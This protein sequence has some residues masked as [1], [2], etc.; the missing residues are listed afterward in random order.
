ME[1]LFLFDD[2]VEQSVKSQWQIYVDGA[3]RNNPGQAGAGV[4]IL[5]NGEPFLKK[6]YYLGI[7]TNNQ[8]EYTAL[9]LAL[10][11]IESTFE[12]DDTMSI[13]SDSKLMI[14]QLQ[15]I[16]KINNA[17]LKVLYHYATTFLRGKRTAFYHIMREANT[18][19]DKL[20]NYGIDK[21]IAVPEEF[22][23]FCST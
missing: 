1:Q 17:Q 11:H 3:S 6:G 9:L 16:Y 18:I 19:A 20:A 4:Y 21:R 12:R 13:F 23:K 15:N 10:Y 7:M 5:K 2:P 8:A 14:M 22:K